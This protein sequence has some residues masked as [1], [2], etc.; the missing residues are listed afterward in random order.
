MDKIKVLG[1][2]DASKGIEGIYKSLQS[3]KDSALLKGENV[4]NMC[5]VAF[6]INYD[7][8]PEPVIKIRKDGQNLYVV[9]VNRQI[10]PPPPGIEDAKEVF[11]QLQK[12]LNGNPTYKGFHITLELLMRWK[13]AEDMARKLIN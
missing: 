1:I 4:E 6:N 8:D 10:L 5:T 11:K 13:D 7:D 2:V 12:I 3:I 9:A